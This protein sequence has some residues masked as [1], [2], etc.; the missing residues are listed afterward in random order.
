M[1]RAGLATRLAVLALLV[2]APAML[3]T[4]RTFLLTEILIFGLFAASLDLLLG[5]TGLP[6][7]GHAGYFGVGGYAAGLFALHVTPNAFAQ[8]AVALGVA[9]GV[10]LVTGVFAVRSRGVYFL[11]LTLAFG[12][13]L[14]VLALNWTSLTGGSN[15]IYGIPAP[16]L[17]G[18]SSWLV[19]SDH[20]YWYTLGVFLVGYVALK[21]VVASPFGRAL[22]GIRGNEERM[23]SL[24][25]SV[26]LSKLAVFTLA[27]AIAGFAGAL[28]CQQSKYFS[29]DGMSFDVSAVAVV[30][31]VIGGQRT[32]LGAVLGAAFYYVMRDQLSDAL[33]S[34]WQLVLG[35][36]FVLVVYLLPGGLVSGG[37]RLQRRVVR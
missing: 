34:H 12:Q 29:P 17:G 13:L 27:G 16:T 14:W 33:S 3:D 9:A 7:L 25:Y 2:A 4:Y 28:A 23:G 35:A 18:S 1:T 21:F 22:A 32:L 31:I 26:P 8:L 15:G 11:M 24:G 36:V 20:F 5:Y 10:A 37:R 19:P 30:V 6:S